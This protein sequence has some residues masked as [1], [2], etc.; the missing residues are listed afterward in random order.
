MI[1]WAALSRGIKRWLDR[2]V[3]GEEA[4]CDVCE[5]PLPPP[6]PVR[7]PPPRTAG[8]LI[9]SDELPPIGV[10]CLSC[11][12]ELSLQDQLDE[13]RVCPACRGQVDERTRSR[14]A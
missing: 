8:E 9:T 12:A 14:F 2:L 3:Y 5:G 11:A 4:S 6:A 1:R 7:W 10:H 13:L